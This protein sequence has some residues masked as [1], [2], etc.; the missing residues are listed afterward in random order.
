MRSSQRYVAVRCRAKSA[1][2]ASLSPAAIRLTRLMSAEASP[3]LA[4]VAGTVAA[5]DCGRLNTFNIWKIPLI[6]SCPKKAEPSDVV[7]HYFF[8]EVRNQY[9]NFRL[10]RAQL[11]PPSEVT[12][13]ASYPL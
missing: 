4:A 2:M 9:A 6:T 12:Y 8:S 13:K 5:A 3:T 7:P 1:C 11:S 10:E